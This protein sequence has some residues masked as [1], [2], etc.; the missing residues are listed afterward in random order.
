MSFGLFLPV[1]YL[2]TWLLNLELPIMNVF[3]QKNPSFYH[4]IA[5]LNHFV[6]FYAVE[7]KHL[8]TMVIN[9]RV[10]KDIQK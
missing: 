1:D 10:I 7:N 2:G 4:F 9:Y 6:T 3:S 5:I 8:M